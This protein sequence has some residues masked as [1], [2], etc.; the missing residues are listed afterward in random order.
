MDLSLASLRKGKNAEDLE[1][2]L[3]RLEGKVGSISAVVVARWYVFQGCGAVRGGKFMCTSSSEMALGGG[4]VG[5]GRCPSMLKLK[6]STRRNAGQQ[7]FPVG[8]LYPV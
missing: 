1:G 3:A 7:T 8:Q 4:R 5:W 6:W 2:E